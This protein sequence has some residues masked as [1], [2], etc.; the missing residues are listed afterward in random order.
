MPIDPEG[1]KLGYPPP[2]PNSTEV[3]VSA[4][5]GYRCFCSFGGSSIPYDYRSYMLCGYT[6]LPGGLKVPTQFEIDTRSPTLL[7]HLGW[8]HIGDIWYR[9]FEP[10]ALRV[11]GVSPDETRPFSWISNVPIETVEEPPYR[12]GQVLHSRV[13]PVPYKPAPSKPKPTLVISRVGGRL[14]ARPQ[15]DS[16]WL[17]R[18][19]RRLSPRKVPLTQDCGTESLQG[20]YLECSERVL[21]SCAARSPTRSGDGILTLTNLRVM[22]RPDFFARIQGAR[23]LELRNR[24][25]TDVGLKTFESTRLPSSRKVCLRLVL[26]GDREELFVVEDA[27]RSLEQFSK[28]I[29]PMLG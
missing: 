2:R 15:V 16:G 14:V 8:W 24:E 5:E 22:Y 4:D 7:A 3:D 9:P 20:I 25:V 6:I 29:T 12:E 1:S 17:A 10:E 27:M 18:V 21:W 13:P 23:P 11:L 28:W 26:V 19:R